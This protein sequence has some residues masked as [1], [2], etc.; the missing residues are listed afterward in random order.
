V[1]SSRSG[2]WR[3]FGLGMGSMFDGWERSIDGSIFEWRV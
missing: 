1:R 2:R 3:R